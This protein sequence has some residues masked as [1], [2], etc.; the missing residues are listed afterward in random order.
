MNKLLKTFPALLIALVLALA[1]A[2]G[3]GGN[4]SVSSDGNDGGSSGDVT[5]NQPDGGSLSDVVVSSSADVLG[6]SAQQ[7]E[8]NVE[9]MRAEF[10]MNV[11]MAGFAMGI[12]GEF[13]FESPDKVYMTIELDSGDASFI[14]MSELGSM[15]VLALGTD[16]YFNIPFLGGWFV[17]SADDLGAEIE[18]FESIFETHSPFDYGMFIDGVGEEVVDLGEESIDGGTFLHYRITVDIADAM[19]AVAQAFGESD[20]FGFSELPVDSFTEPLVMDLWVDPDNFLPHRIEADM[21]LDV[22]GEAV[23]FEMVFNF[24]DYNQDVGIPAPPEDAKSFAELFAGLFE[25]FEGEE[26]SFDFGE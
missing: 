7:F 21:A 16:I 15:E 8:Q 11:D 20:T 10:L 1:V 9:S 23:G 4:D 18:T 17:M 6:A 5:S 2:C 12:E 14:D 3:G 22:E 19:G 25:G 24:F 13:A 26:F